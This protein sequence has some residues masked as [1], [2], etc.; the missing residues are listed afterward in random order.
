MNRMLD[1]KLRL[2]SE[3]NTN[4]VG[5][6]NLKKN[7]KTSSEHIQKLLE[8][9]KKVKSFYE[10]NNLFI[11]DVLIDVYYNDTIC[12]TGRISELLKIK[13]DC[14]DSIV[15]ARFS[16]SKEGEEN[17]IITHYVPMNV[18]DNAINKLEIAKSFIENELNK[19]ANSIN[20]D[21]KLQ[22]NYSNYNLS[23][24]K[25]R[26][27]IID[28]SVLTNF[29]IPNVKIDSINDSMIVTFYQ[30]ELDIYT[31]LNKLEIDGRKYYYSSA[32]KNTLSVSKETLEKLVSEVPYLISMTAVDISKIEYEKI[33]VTS[34]E[35]IFIPTP[36]N[37][38]TIGVIDTLFDDNVYFS[39]WVEYHE[40]LDEVEKLTK[41]NADYVH[42]TSVTSLIVDGVTLNPSLDDGC[43]RFKVRHFGV[44][45][46]YITISKL[47]KKIEDIIIKNQDIHVWNLSL[48]TTDEVSK[49]FISFD[50]AAID[51][52]EQKYNIIFVIS[53]TNDLR[54]EPKNPK[55]LRVGSPADSLNSVVVNSVRKDGTPA[56]YSRKGKVL[57][58]F[59]KPDVSCFGGDF[60]ERINVYT[61]NGLDEQY[62]TSFAAPWI[63]RKLCYLIDVL[64]FT[65]E[66]A[67][68]L[69]IDAAAGWRFKQSQYKM[70]NL[71]GFGVVPQ[72]INDILNSEDDEIKFVLKGISNSYYTT[73]YAI[74]VPKNNGNKSFYIARA[75]L[76]YFP[77]CNRLQGVDY[78]QRELSLKFGIVNNESIQDINFNTQDDDDK[79]V[80]ERKAREKFRKWENTKFIS[81]L[82]T[83]NKARGKS[84]YNEGFWGISITSKERAR[85]AKMDDLKF[86]VVVTLKN[87]KGENRLE[88]FKHSCLL[89]GY[90]VNE[91]DIK[92]K[93]EFYNDAQEEIKF[94]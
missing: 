93:I 39:S 42:G 67:K 55:T 91:I 73:N 14:N 11:K 33:A 87:K 19:E 66:V 62:G 68:A 8:D 89:Q 52:L 2:N 4:K 20:F 88:E 80:S 59:N 38:P 12:K 77:E 57:S 82:L 76:C 1:I 5:S 71:I 50:A 15:G 90:L 56:T 44:S 70:E 78:T 51:S 72:N 45:T 34:K 43:G 47:V 60:D 31:L 49:N 36:K 18:I 9:L 7:A 75:T 6:K 64:K 54:K 37:E 92:N 84:L 69:L 79:H 86:G 65:R 35:N 53:G 28:C 61:P 81:S 29:G 83:T 30:T 74:P 3:K 32:G 26:D 40:T 13:G 16:D 85:V 22:L 23:K 46:G 41:A 10:K 27:T 63:S 94:D 24:T 17:H 25:L 58:F 21:S 48:G